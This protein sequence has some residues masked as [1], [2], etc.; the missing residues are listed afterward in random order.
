M[1]L[2]D[3]EKR[4]EIHV[5]GDPD[6]SGSTRTAKFQFIGGDPA[7]SVTERTRTGTISSGT[8]QLFT[9]FYNEITGQEGGLNE[10]IQIDL[11]TGQFLV[12]LSFSSWS[13][14]SDFD[15]TLLQWGDTGDETT[16]TKTDATGEHA[17]RKM[18][19]LSYWLKNTRTDSLPDN[20]AGALGSGGVAEIH[21]GQRSSQGVYDPVTVAFEEPSQTFNGEQPTTFSGSLTG[22][23]IADLGET[24]DAEARTPR[25]T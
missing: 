21:Y 5:T 19:C 25:G 6:G 24:Y 2:E 22:V 18:Q 16:L 13:G 17:L 10:E 20:L 9:T 7:I 4:F 3:Y 8:A 15:G 11:G 12:E 23:A 14:E 1:E